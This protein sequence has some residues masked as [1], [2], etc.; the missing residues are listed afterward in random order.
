MA[1][2]HDEQEAPSEIEMRRERVLQL[3]MRRMSEAA[4]AAIVGV[5]EATVS[6]DLKWIRQQWKDR[7]GTLPN[8]D[9]AEEVGA[10][11]ALYEEAEVHAMLEFARINQENKD[12]NISPVYGAK[13]RMACLKLAGEMRTKR[14]NLL[15]DL[16]I[17]DRAL[18]TLTVQLPRA[19]QIRETIRTATVTDDML[20]PPAERGG[21][22]P[23]KPPESTH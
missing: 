2:E 5:H 20:L 7:Y 15:Q 23:E 12:R 1:D 11:L 17:I 3:R 9:P 21:E 10:A 22:P 13:Q 6:R 8:F 18:G 16:G 19:K 4:I 14:V